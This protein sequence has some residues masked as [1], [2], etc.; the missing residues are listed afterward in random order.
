[1][2]APRRAGSVPAKPALLGGTPVRTEPF[3]SW[4][5]AG[6]LEERELQQV[7]RSGQWNRHD[8]VEAFETEYAALTG[9]EHCLATA[10]GTSALL[11]SLVALGVGPGDEVIVPPYTFVATIN[12]VLLRHALPVFVDSD[13]ETFQIDAS[14]IEAAVTDRTRVILPVHLGGS[15]A[16]LDTILDV[17]V[18]RGVAVVEDA[19]QSHL[20]EWRG[21]K[22]GSHGKTGCFSF[23]ASKNLNC[24]EGGAIISND[25]AVIEECY[26]FHNNSRGRALAGS[27]DFSYRGIGANLRLTEFQAALLRAQMTRLEAQARRRDT[28]GARLS[29][30]LSAIP[31]VTPARMYDGCTRNAYH[32]YMF[33][34]DARAFADLPRA[35]FLEA[36][37]AEGIPASGGYS[38]LDQEPV[39]TDTLASRAYARLYG[40]A[41]LARLRGRRAIWTRSPKPSIAFARMPRIWSR[42]DPGEAVPPAL[43]PA[44]CLVALALM[45]MS[46]GECAIVSAQDGGTQSPFQE[47]V[48]VSRVLVD[49]RVVG[50]GSRPVEGLTADD[51]EVRIDGR[52][53][54][55][56]SAE[57]I[58]AS[59]RG[60]RDDETLTAASGGR[61]IVLFFQRHL[62]ASR[63]H[64]L[65]KI[66]RQ[67][68]RLLSGIVDDDRVAVLT[69][70]SH[71]E[72]TLDFTSDRSRL[73][74][75]LKDDVL[76]GP[77]PGE[78]SQPAAGGPALRRVL[79]DR[80]AKGFESIDHALEWLGGA[81]EPLPG[82]K[83]VVLVGYGM[84]MS[85]SDTYSRALAALEHARAAVFAL[86]V[87]DAD[88]HSLER[89]LQHLS[90]QTGGWFARAYEMP[91]SVVQRVV[92]ALAGHYVLIVEE[93][94]GLAPGR[95]ELHVTL[96][97]GSG[98]VYARRSYGGGG[99]IGEPE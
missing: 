12:V 27:S 59:R 14:R 86:D 47:H 95:H 15:S 83:A 96:T 46:G 94:S 7:L 34:F 3:P 19:C 31:G 52:P 11:T 29:R 81:L 1:M 63:I 56:E 93:P 21:R 36:L 54:R 98:T 62:D 44:P 20:A 39:V 61:L 84:A 60:R 32:I 49:A 87:T 23:Q 53:S 77:T 99:R 71:L 33:R 10:N 25:G 28:N 66:L 38:P 82:G 72:L 22:V 41:E 67:R 42:P 68:R 26:R 85:E 48:T 89:G 73:E 57:W 5:V 70:G 40:A 69:F 35:R 92:G 4:P 80:T 79:D 6:E 37:R 76:G 91:A 18:R 51:F 17:A 45:V 65:V 30:L 13:L 88:R 50:R 24:G 16:D 90:H 9:T 64:G 43:V 97:S 8:Q 74:Q 2:A 75:A 58:G 78:A 55:V